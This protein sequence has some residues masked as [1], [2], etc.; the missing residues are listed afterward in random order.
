VYFG[1]GTPSAIQTRLVITLSMEIAEAITPE[2]VY[3][4]PSSSSAPCTVPSSPKRPCSAMKQRLKPLR[5]SS[6]RSRFGGVEGVR[7]DALGLQ[8]LQHAAPDISDTSRSADLPPMRTADLAE[9]LGIHGWLMP[10]PPSSTT[11][12]GTPPIEPAPMHI[13]TSPSAH[14]VQDG[15]RQVGDVAHELRFHLAGHAHRARERAAVG[16]HD[17]LLARRIDLGQQ[18]HVGVPSTCTKSSKQSRVRV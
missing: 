16:R 15:L 6:T 3:G 10:W 13:T 18:H 11:F 8:R 14:G 4:M 17:R 2:P 7:V 12:A 9:F 5:L 1:V